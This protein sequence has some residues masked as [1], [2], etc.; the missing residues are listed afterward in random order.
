MHANAEEALARAVAAT[1]TEREARR[2]AEIDRT[3]AEVRLAQLRD[4]L[5]RVTF[6]A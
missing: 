2:Q 3:A 6:G 4:D 1:A 5:E